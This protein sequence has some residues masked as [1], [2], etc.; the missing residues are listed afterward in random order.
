MRFQGGLR[1]RWSAGKVVC[2][3]GGLAFLFAKLRAL[4]LAAAGTCMDLTTAARPTIGGEIQLARI[5][6]KVS[7]GQT[8]L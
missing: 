8:Q 5:R 3:E 6:F 7:C 1:G 4:Q 2:G